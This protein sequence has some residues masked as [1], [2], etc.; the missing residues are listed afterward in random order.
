MIAVLLANGFEE[1]EAIGTVDILRRAKLDASLVAVGDSNTVSSARDVKVIADQSVEETDWAKIEA[2]VLPGGLDGV[3]NLSKCQEVR[4]QLI[5]LSNEGKLVAAICAAPMLL[6][7]LGLLKGKNATCYPGIE[8]NCK[9]NPEDAV[10]K[11]GNIITS[12]GAGTTHL[13]AA[14][15]VD[16]I[17]KDNLS[18]DILKKMVYKK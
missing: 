2:I 6:S 15:I 13:F 18:L 17:L 4:N 14:A 7:E 12:K 11:D 9:T 10:V 3:K 16:Y 1:I 8:L 5:K